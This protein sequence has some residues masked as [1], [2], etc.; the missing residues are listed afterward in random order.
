MGVVTPHFERKMKL[1]PLFIFPFSGSFNE[2]V[3]N[4]TLIAH[5]REAVEPLNAESYLHNVQHGCEDVDQQR[6]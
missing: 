3:K 2:R 5:L 1:L 4:K 6:R